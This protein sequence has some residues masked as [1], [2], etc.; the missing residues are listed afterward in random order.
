M[1]EKLKDYFEMSKV[2]LSTKDARRF[3][4]GALIVGLVIGLIIGAKLSGGS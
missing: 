4:A 1:I 3:F 2:L